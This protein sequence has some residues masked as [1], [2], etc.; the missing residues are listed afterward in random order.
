MTTQN[1]ETLDISINNIIHQYSDMVYKLA[2]ARTKNKADAEDLF[3]EVFLKCYKANLQFNSQ[4]HCKAWLI[5]VTVN[6]SKNF[7]TSAWK[8]RNILTETPLWDF[9]KNNPDS[10]G[11]DKSEVFYAVMKLPEKYRI[12][13]HLYYYEDFSVTEIANILNRKESTVKTQLLRAR[14]LLKQDLKGEYNYV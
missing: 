13:L 3:Q 14:K 9:E 11:D 7:L 5:R 1:I 2:Y 4:E 10:S 6:L 8:R 12:I